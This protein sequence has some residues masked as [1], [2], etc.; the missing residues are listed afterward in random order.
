MQENIIITG[1]GQVGV[2][3]VK[4]L[5]DITPNKTGKHRKDKIKYD[6]NDDNEINKIKRVSDHK[7]KK[8]NKKKTR[9]KIGGNINKN[10]KATSN[11]N[12]SD[13]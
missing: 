8:K 6:S 11:N 7:K 13:A 4:N 1:K 3:A 12:K 2:T 10:N 9:T 5:H